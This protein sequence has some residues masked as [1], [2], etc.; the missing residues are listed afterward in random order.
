MGV[1]DGRKLKERDQLIHDIVLES[2][3]K[4]EGVFIIMKSREGDPMANSQRSIAQ[5][6]YP[7]PKDGFVHW[8]SARVLSVRLSVR[9]LIITGPTCN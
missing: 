2:H 6:A 8:A 5:N 7:T 1:K 9:I 3:R 4:G